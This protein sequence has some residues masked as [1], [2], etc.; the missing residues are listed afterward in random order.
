[1][2]YSSSF[3]YIKLA[4]RVGFEPTV[5][6]KPTPIFKTGAINQLDHL[7][8]SCHHRSDNIYIS[9]KMPNMSI[10]IYVFFY[11]SSY[12]IKSNILAK[13]SFDEYCITIFPLLFPGASFTLVPKN[14]WKE[15]SISLYIASCLLS[16]F[17]LLLS[18]L[19]FQFP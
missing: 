12:F 15:S 4:E 5:G 10:E 7:C 19:F 14:P 16:I 17:L 8:T 6:Y 9:T 18:L 3:I 2:F 1:M 13:S 11:F